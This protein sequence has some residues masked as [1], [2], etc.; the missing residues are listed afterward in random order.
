[1][2]LPLVR[3]RGTN[4]GWLATIQTKKRPCNA[5]SSVTAHSTPTLDA[6]TPSAGPS[7]WVACGRYVSGWPWA[8]VRNDLVPETGH[9]SLGRQ[10][11]A[12]MGDT[13]STPSRHQQLSSPRREGPDAHLLRRNLVCLS[14]WPA[15]LSP[16]CLCLGCP[17]ER[18]CFSL[19]IIPCQFCT[20]FRLL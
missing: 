19:P 12:R 1:M 15:S 10:G 8:A 4:S 11:M 9:L 3:P 13:N 2:G 17:A 20:G 14:C 5:N 6:Q 7:A 16:L 18:I